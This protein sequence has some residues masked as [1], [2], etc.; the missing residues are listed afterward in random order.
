MEHHKLDSIDMRI[1]S[2][3]RTTAGS[4]VDFPAS[5][6]QH[7]SL[8]ED[9]ALE[10]RATS[11][12]ITPISTQDADFQVTGCVRRI[13]QPSRCGPQKKFEQVRAWPTVRGCF[14]LSGEVILS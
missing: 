5:K 6:L 10:N 2:N 7:L 14:M 12:D 1:L 9:R 13:E 11:K 8:R 4:C 3:F